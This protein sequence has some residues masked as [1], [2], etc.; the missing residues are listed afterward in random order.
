MKVLIFRGHLIK[1]KVI[2]MNKINLRFQMSLYFDIIKVLV[3]NK[4]VKVKKKIW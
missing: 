1:I 4:I 3:K 2:L